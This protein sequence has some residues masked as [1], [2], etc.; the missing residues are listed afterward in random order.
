[1]VKQELLRL[2][3]DPSVSTIRLPDIT[4]RDQISQAFPLVFVHC[5]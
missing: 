4:A 1:M 3:T 5:E 2:N